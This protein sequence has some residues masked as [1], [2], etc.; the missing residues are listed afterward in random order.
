MF[1]DHQGSTLFFFLAAGTHIP[2][3]SV[4]VMKPVLWSK[5]DLAIVINE[6]LPLHATLA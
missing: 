6:P 5:S 3:A 1:V 4:V 2:D